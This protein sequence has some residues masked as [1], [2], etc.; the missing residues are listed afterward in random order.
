MAKS[1]FKIV[2]VS[3]EIPW[4]VGA[5]GRTCVGLNLE[6]IIVGPTRIDI[7]D[8]A[9]KRAGLDYWQYVKLKNY[10]SWKDFLKQEKPGMQDLFFFSTKAK[11]IFFE[12]DFHDGCYLVFGSET[13][14]L[15][16][17]Y[18]K[19]YKPRFFKLPMYND[20]IRSFNLANAAT[21]AAFEAVRQI[22][23]PGF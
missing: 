20:K 16:P 1:F 9:V 5:I 13:K 7:S 17:G 3:P 11:N 22:K 19:Q 2:L 14:G 8:K 18:H 10:E 12:A 15:A 23:F 6:L 21:S 4:N